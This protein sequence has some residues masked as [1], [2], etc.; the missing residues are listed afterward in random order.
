MRSET[1]QDR[2]EAVASARH[3]DVVVELQAFA[4]T[5]GDFAAVS[6]LSLDIRRGEVFGFLGPNGAGKTTTIECMV[7]LQRPTGGVIRVLGHDP[8]TDRDA[9]TRRVAVQPQSASLFDTLTV[10]ETVELFASFHERPRPVGEILE[11]VGLSD[12]AAER[13]KRLSGGQTRR[14][15]L[16]VA[17]VADPEVLVLDEPSAGLDPAARQALWDVIYGLRDRGTTI[18]LSTH[19]MDEATS[20]CDR[21]A[22]LVGGRLAAMDSP[23]ELIRQHASVSD[24]AFTVATTVSDDDLAEALQQPYTS[25]AVRGGVRVHVT[26]GDPDALIRRVTFARGLRARELNVRAGSLEDIFLRLAE[27]PDERRT[28]RDAAMKGNR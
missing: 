8:S 13:A 17:L 21:V 16:A 4:K 12:Q 15:L 23:D 2:N 1:G 18:V 7:G 26:T 5:F 3:G 9:I 20:V 10:E 28:D 11:E 14:L 19:H 27:L 24:V 6:D 25:E 22:I